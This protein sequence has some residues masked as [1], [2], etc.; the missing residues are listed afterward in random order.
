MGASQFACSIEYAIDVWLIICD[1]VGQPEILKLYSFLE[2][3][4]NFKWPVSVPVNKWVRSKIW[5]KN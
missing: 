3:S 1:P 4:C 2:E 5:R